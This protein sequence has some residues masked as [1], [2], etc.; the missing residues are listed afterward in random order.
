MKR[1]VVCRRVDAA[2]AAAVAQDACGSRIPAKTCS[3][4]AGRRRQTGS[5][6]ELQ[7]LIFRGQL[8]SAADDGSP[9]DGR[10]EVRFVARLFLEIETYGPWSA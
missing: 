9:L 10:V 5:V 2:A 6:R 7:S 1:T 4:A 3:C 8:R